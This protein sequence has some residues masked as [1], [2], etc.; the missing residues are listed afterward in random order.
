MNIMTEFKTIR[1][2]LLLLTLLMTASLVSGCSHT[3]EVHY[4]NDYTVSPD[5]DVET[6]ELMEETGMTS[7]GGGPG[8]YR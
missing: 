5:A 1:F 2:G 4:A 3:G 7:I 8:G 6:E